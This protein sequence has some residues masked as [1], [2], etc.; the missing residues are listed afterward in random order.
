[1]AA[2][3]NDSPPRFAKLALA[4]AFGAAALGAAPR[5]A[6]ALDALLDVPDPAVA[7]ASAAYRYANMTDAAAYAELDRRHVAYVKVD[8]ANAPGV[9]APIR[10]AGSLHG[11]SFHSA[12]P[13]DQRATSPF[14]ILDARLAL[15]LDDFAGILEHHD[16]DDVTHFSLYRPGLPLRATAQPTPLA[17]PHVRST[18]AQA[19]AAHGARAAVAAHTTPLHAAAHDPHGYVD[20]PVFVVVPHARASGDK[21]ASKATPGAAPKLVETHEQKQKEGADEAKPT[22]YVGAPSAP[23]PAA[24]GTRHPAGLAIDVGVLHKKDGHTINVG[25]SFHGHVGDRTCGA[26]APMPGDPSARELRSIV[27]EARDLGVFTYVLTP[28]YN[29]AHVDHLHMEIKP[30]VRWFL[31]H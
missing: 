14:E 5:E 12:L 1:V 20:E 17:T 21:R 8:A 26:G 2:A 7:E 19:R 25:A 18:S 31:Y 29:A 10:L 13:V 11:V 23:S 28:N 24:P 15:A 30:G 9:R 6:R 27:C 3:V 16:V 4:A 22:R